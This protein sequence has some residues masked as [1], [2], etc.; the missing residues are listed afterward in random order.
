MKITML[1]RGTI[2]TALMGCSVFGWAAEDTSVKMA[3]AP[4]EDEVTAVTVFGKLN[5]KKPS[6]QLHRIDSSRAS[7]CNFS[8]TRSAAEVEDEYMDFF[9]GKNHSVP[10]V[11]PGNSETNSDGHSDRPDP[12]ATDDGRNPATEEKES[13]S[14]NA[15]SGTA[16]ANVKIA[17]GCNRS[18]Y[19][20]AAGRNHI[21]RKDKTLTE[22]FAAYDA[23]NFSL[24]LETFKKSWDKVGYDEAALMLGD[25]YF[26]G[27]GT[28]IDIPQAVKWYI[29]V[30]EA[31]Y[32]KDQLN[33]FDPANPDEA[34]ARVQ[35]QVKL[36]RIYLLGVGVGKDPKQARHWYEAA[37]ELGYVPA[38]YRL[39]QFYFKNIGGDK[40]SKAAVKLLK[41]AAESGYA[42][43]Q[44]AL[45]EW[46][47]VQE[48]TPENAKSAF[49]WYEQAAFNPHPDN[50]KPYAQFAL[51]ESYE[52]GS[53]V[54]AD[55]QKAFA[56]YKLSAVA[57]HPDAQYA[58]GTYF[59]SGEMGKK[60][61]SIARRLFEAAANQQQTDAMFSLGV[62]LM[63]GEGGE[64][65]KVKS[66]VWLTLAGK[67]GNTKAP[68][69][70]AKV[71]S[72]LTPEQKQQATTLLKPKV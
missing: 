42:A 28:A 47:F 61:F 9:Y 55:P 23:E 39:A 10:T 24:A 60:D 71:D 17:E 4:K 32:N 14:D 52:R 30:T 63:K 18:D 72:Q 33:P 45:A 12:L 1:I 8:T 40:N 51:A 2:M 5:E 13:F 49:E 20:A 46:Y 6:K 53:G 3:S 31:R 50:K 41:D 34:S 27:Q 29:K 68:A 44:Y 19:N 22:A 69:I 35:A 38:K 66:F 26:F 43:A 21:L 62:M 65:D 15:P 56:F 58:L 7:N 36:A 37:S 54:K 57:G 64:L 59:Y 48:E 16:E 67:L 25:M 70:A 11:S